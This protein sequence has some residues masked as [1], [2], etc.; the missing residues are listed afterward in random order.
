MPIPHWE[1][2]GCSDKLRRVAMGEKDKA[3]EET[4]KEIEAE[5]T[6]RLAPFA[7]SK[8]NIGIGEQITFGDNP[9]IVCT[10]VE[11]KAVE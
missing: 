10:V 4:A 1:I 11:D 2:Y 7:F 9:D 6:E 3:A 8:C 5:H